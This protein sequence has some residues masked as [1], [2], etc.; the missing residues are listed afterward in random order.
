MQASENGI[1]SFGGPFFVSSPQTF[2]TFF[3]FASLMAPFW[4][5]A[6]FSRFGTLLHRVSTDFDTLQKASNLT[7]SLFPNAGFEAGQV[8]VI[9]WFQVA[10]REFPGGNEVNTVYPQL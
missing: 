10:R 6:D 7:N 8:V 4:N 5:D 2:G 1:I 3:S 9:T